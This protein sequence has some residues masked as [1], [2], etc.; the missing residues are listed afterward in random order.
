MAVHAN[1]RG[2]GAQMRTRMNEVDADRDVGRG[3]AIRCASDWTV[4]PRFL[5]KELQ[6]IMRDAALGEQRVDKLIQVQLRDG[7][8]E[9]ILMHLEVQHRREVRGVETVRSEPSYAIHHQH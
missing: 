3:Q 6:E 7:T 4:S 8:Q 2:E 1:V 9:W 5:D